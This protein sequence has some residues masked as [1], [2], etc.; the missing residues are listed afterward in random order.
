MTDP[1]EQIAEKLIASAYRH[2][3]NPGEAAGGDYIAIVTKDTD[4]PAHFRRIA[5]LAAAPRSMDLHEQY[6][7]AT[8]H[9]DADRDADMVMHAGLD[10][11]LKDTACPPNSAA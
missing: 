6:R 3:G 11:L 8:A 10:H 1:V 4:V 2:F 9:Y 5:K 7:E